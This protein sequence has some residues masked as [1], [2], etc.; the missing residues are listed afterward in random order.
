MLS[1]FS[2]AALLVAALFMPEQ[3]S[4][5]NSNNPT[6]EKEVEKAVEKALE[7]T[8]KADEKSREG[9]RAKRHP[10]KLTPEQAT[11]A[12]A[13]YQKYC[14]L[15]HGADRAGYANDH[16]PSLKSASLMESGVPHGVLRA[17]SYGRQGTAMAGYLDEVGG[18][19]S[20]DET[21]DLAYWLYWQ[22]G[23]QA[24]R[25]S[26][27][28][29]VGDVALGEI[30]F[31]QTCATCH[32]EAG[33]G[34]KQAP[35][36]ANPSALAHNKDEFIRYAIQW[37]RE[38]TPMQSF[39]GKLKDSEIDALTAY[40]RSLEQTAQPVDMPVLKAL[41]KPADYIINP[42]GKDPD[43]TLKDGK[44]VT[45]PDLK[46]ALGDKNRMVILD[47]RVPS[48]WQRS[49]IAGSVPVPY[50]TDIDKLMRDI[51][52]GVQIIAYCSCPRAAADH[53]TSKLT[54]KGYTRTAVLWE[55]VFGWM[56]QGYPVMRG[57][58][59]KGKASHAPDPDH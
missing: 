43:F 6:E 32:G 57:D 11:R 30:L 18:P 13:N 55:G 9:Y 59:S 41:P 48:V 26:E 14:S 7:K 52:K 47:T 21:W 58:V 37:G 23:A 39:K 38:G 5:N 17:L 16:A 44:Y 15:C 27:D 33:S 35:M 31:K 40:I 46:K 42:D 51:P 53:L 34:G 22:A 56:Q 29:V 3:A 2:V 10:R 25:L 54:D 49:H 19:L 24:M 4:K 36:L 50:Y 20:L 28:P 12:S 8:A 1:R 45:S